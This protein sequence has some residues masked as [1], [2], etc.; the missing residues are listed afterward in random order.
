VKTLASWA[1]SIPV[2]SFACSNAIQASVFTWDR[3]ADGQHA[4]VTGLIASSD[5]YLHIFVTAAPRKAGEMLREQL[6]SDMANAVT[7]MEKVALSRRDGGFGIDP[8]TWFVN[9]SR[10]MDMLS[11]V[12]SAVRATLTPS[13]G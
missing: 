4:I 5:S 9:M 2:F 10:K 8:T 6:R 13:R 1:R 11:D 7:E 12:E 3:Y